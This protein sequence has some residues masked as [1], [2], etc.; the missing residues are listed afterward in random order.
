MTEVQS[1]VAL[2]DQFFQDFKN[3]KQEI[4]K[5]IIGQDE[6]VNLML[7]SILSRNL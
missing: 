4:S 1:E 5:V 3:L 7:T 2:A 6:V